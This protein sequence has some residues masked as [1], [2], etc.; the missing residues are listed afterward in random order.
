VQPLNAEVWV[1]A[2]TSANMLLR[3]HLK[4]QH[5]T[6]TSKRFLVIKLSVSM[7]HQLLRRPLYAERCTLLLQGTVKQHALTFWRSAV[8]MK[9]QE[10]LRSA[11]V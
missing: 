5:H 8:N 1:I 3:L 6:M 10:W 4:L 2:S 9:H 7:Q 11:Y